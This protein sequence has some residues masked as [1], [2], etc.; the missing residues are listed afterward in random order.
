MPGREFKPMSPTYRPPT[1]TQTPTQKPPDPPPMKWCSGDPAQDALDQLKV[2]L[3]WGEAKAKEEAARK[4]AL[5][6]DVAAMEA[7]QKDIDQVLKECEQQYLV[8]KGER[9]QI[10]RESDQR[11]DDARGVLK[12][13]DLRKLDDT[14]NCVDEAY[15]LRKTAY[16]DLDKLWY[17]RNTA[18]AAYD[19]KVYQF[20]AAQREF[21][22]Y[23]SYLKRLQGSTQKLKEYKARMADE[24]GKKNYAALYAVTHLIDVNYPVEDDHP[25]L[26]TVEQLRV[27]L[28][29]VRDDL[30][31]ARNALR[32][33]KIEFDKAK[34]ALDQ[35]PKKL[36]QAR[37]IRAR[38][39]FAA[40]A[41]VYEQ[42][43]QQ[44]GKQP[45]PAAAP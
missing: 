20:G 10:K 17:Q 42:Q 18:Q 24:L 14:I 30:N 22:K 8:I 9:R 2:D 5:Q 37:A 13:G 16:F 11:K 29:A 45:A 44:Q 38:D 41:R 12:P 19:E 40:A 33:A 32:E 43:Q 4:D 39:L 25:A 31:T 23:K 15:Q 35:A 26:L 36:E 21:E 1:T 6:K 3:E 27:K 34:A 28:K 7:A